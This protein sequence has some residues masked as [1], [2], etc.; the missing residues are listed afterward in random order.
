MKRGLTTAL[1]RPVLG[2]RAAAEAGVAPGPA[3]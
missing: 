1:P 2:V 3:R